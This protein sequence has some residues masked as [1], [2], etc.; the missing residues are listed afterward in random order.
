[1]LHK[2]ALLPAFWYVLWCV[3]FN[4]FTLFGKKQ[5]LLRSPEH[6]QPVN[7]QDSDGHTPLHL[8]CID[9]SIQCVNLLLQ[10]CLLCVI[11]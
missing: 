5:E 9:G 6:V 4:T 10:V 8:A 1:M 11:G 7:Y 2:S 3:L